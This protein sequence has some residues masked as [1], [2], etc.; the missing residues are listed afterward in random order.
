MNNPGCQYVGL[1]DK[2]EW[3]IGGYDG[4]VNKTKRNRWRSVNKACG[5][6]YLQQRYM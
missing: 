3:M 5:G 2:W 4:D 6:D 1:E